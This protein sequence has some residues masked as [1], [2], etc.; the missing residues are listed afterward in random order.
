MR[1]LVTG[2]AGFIGTHLCRA[3]A[4]RSDEVVGVDVAPEPWRA[5]QALG[6]DDVSLVARVTASVDNFVTDDVRYFVEP[7]MMLWRFSLPP[8][9]AIVHLAG[10]SHIS[11]C[12]RAPLSAIHANVMSVSRVL[13]Y[14]RSVGAL[15]VLPSS[16]HAYAGGTLGRPTPYTEA[17]PLDPRD[18]YGATKACADILGRA[19]IG[20]GVPVA[21]LRHVNAY[22]PV[23]A[24]SHLVPSVIRD[25][26]NGTPPV[27]KSDGTPVKS[28]LH[29]DDVVAAYLAAIDGLARSL[30]QPG[31]YNVA[32]RTARS[33][34]SMVK[35]LI[36]ISGVA[37]EPKVTCEDMSQSGYVELLDSAKF[38]NATGWTPRVDLRDGL[39]RTWEWYQRHRDWLA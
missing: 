35:L 34:L 6:V 27:I 1:I 38:E 22:G 17:D 25:L 31:A 2:A 10:M 28:Y 9:N 20:F 32:P 36:E 4:E 7:P 39:R 3:L 8:P 13:E 33:V 15:V 21:I 24:P 18:V 30:L 23:A 14:A 26:L 37:V 16:N 19:W 11:A 5:H 29:V 12:Q